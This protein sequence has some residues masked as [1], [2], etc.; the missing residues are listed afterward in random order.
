MASG[1]FGLAF[2]FPHGGRLAGTH[3]ILTAAYDGFRA[4]RH[5]SDDEAGPS[6][7]LVTGAL[8]GRGCQVG[9]VPDRV[10]RFGESLGSVGVDPRE[11]VSPLVVFRSRGRAQARPLR[12]GLCAPGR[13]LARACARQGALGLRYPLWRCDYDTPVPTTSE[14]W[15]PRPGSEP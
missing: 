3:S 1:R 8:H 11:V 9:K 14:T 12:P 2:L 4:A 5:L 13:V 15:T 6:G 10:A 7:G